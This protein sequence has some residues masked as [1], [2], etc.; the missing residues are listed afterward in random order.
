MA[1]FCW[2]FSAWFW[3]LSMQ[4]KCLAA[5]K[6]SEL[7]GYDSEWNDRT[8]GF[9]VQGSKETF[10]GCFIFPLSLQDLSK[11]VPGNVTGGLDP[12]GISEDF[13]GQL[14]PPKS[15]QH[16]ALSTNKWWAVNKSTEE[17]KKLSTPSSH[18]GAPWVQAQ[19]S[20]RGGISACFWRIKVI[21][22]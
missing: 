9:K 16:Q 3:C 20:Y 8:A 1:L 14:P 2:A 19:E 22:C 12:D 15:A 5:G 18:Q 13:L 10:D 17:R 6:A 21:G 7:P 4:W 11:A